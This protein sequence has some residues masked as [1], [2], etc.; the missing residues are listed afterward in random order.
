[1]KDLPDSQVEIIYYKKRRKNEHVGQ[2]RER[3][4]CRSEV[5]W[6]GR[7]ETQQPVPIREPSKQTGGS[8]GLAGRDIYAIQPQA[9]IQRGKSN[10]GAMKNPG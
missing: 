6:P 10:L 4:R 5:P 7:P 8:L 1:M 2:S 3:E 9:A